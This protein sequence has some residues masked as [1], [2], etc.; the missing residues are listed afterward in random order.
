MTPSLDELLTVARRYWPTSNAHIERGE[1]SPERDRMYAHWLAEWHR[2][3]PA[4]D[5]FLVEVQ[6]TL[7]Q[8]YVME[9]S[10]PSDAGLRCSVYLPA[11]NRRGT[12]RDI[13][14]GCMSF[15]AP[16]YSVYGVRYQ[17]IHRRRRNPR[18]F[19][20]ELPRRMHWPAQVL[21]ERLEARF[22]LT[23]LPPELAATPVPLF[24]DWQEPPHTTLFHALLTSE[25][26]NLP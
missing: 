14:V 9:G 20:E 17:L 11:E 2:R 3:E 16:V 18:L 13:V 25:P 12:H 26:E 1:R 15:I 5:A 8:S 10:S 7:F 23:R 21:A 6:R 24:V 19:L 4:W 22:G